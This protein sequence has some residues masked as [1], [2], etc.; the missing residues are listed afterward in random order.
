MNDLTGFV[1]KV[2]SC[3]AE[4]NRVEELVE[5]VKTALV[6]LLDPALLPSALFDDS[7]RGPL[8]L[9]LHRSEVVTVFAIASPA[10]FVSRVHD[11]G[12]WGV[13]GQVSGI[14]TEDVYR[15]NQQEVVSDK[16][17]G[18]LVDL[19][20]LASS[21]LRAGEVVSIVPPDRDIHEVRTSMDGPSVTLHAFARDPVSH[22]FKY[23]Q[24][25]LYATHRYSG[26]YDNEPRPPDLER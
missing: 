20:E 6:P 19:Q 15:L 14:E 4:I 24:P 11:H 22:G 2:R 18:G 7:T 9:L 5:H 17:D 10:G 1:E 13:V 23:F 16:E 21:H 8:R 12:C 25:R 3:R 26:I